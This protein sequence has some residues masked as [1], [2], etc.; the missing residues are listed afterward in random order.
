[1]LERKASASK[2]A[3]SV[4][5]G[6]CNVY[7]NENNHTTNYKEIMCLANLTQHHSTSDLC[8]RFIL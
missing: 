1:M 8:R 4:T 5:E 7:L 6:T 2:M 3:G